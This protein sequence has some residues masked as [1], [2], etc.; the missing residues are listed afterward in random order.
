MPPFATWTMWEDTHTETHKH[1][2]T[3]KSTNI[4]DVA[5]IHIWRL[6]L[7][8]QAYCVDHPPPLPKHTDIQRVPQ[9]GKSII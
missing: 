2:L 6:E 9:G 8:L 7:N 5:M 3:Q 4:D 1:R